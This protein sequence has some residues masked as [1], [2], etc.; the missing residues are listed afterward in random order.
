MASMA[1]GHQNFASAVPF[2]YTVD[3]YTVYHH[4]LWYT[5][6]AVQKALLTLSFLSTSAPR[7]NNNST[8]ST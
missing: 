4:N 1:L 8:T 3:F 6:C 7:D 2:S 5:A